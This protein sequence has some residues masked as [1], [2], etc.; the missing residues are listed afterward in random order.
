M[1]V[2]KT[3]SLT[4]TNDARASSDRSGAV[5]AISSAMS[6]WTSGASS[7]KVKTEQPGCDAQE[8]RIQFRST[9][10]TSGADVAVSVDGTNPANRP[11]V[12]TGGT[13]MRYMVH[14]TSGAWAMIHEM[15]HTFGLPDE[16]TQ[17]TGVPI[18]PPPPTPGAPVVIPPSATPSATYVAAPPQ[19]NSTVTLTAS[20]PSTRHPGKYIFDVESVMGRSGNTTFELHHYFWIAIEVK[21]LMEEE[22]TPAVV[23]II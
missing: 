22:G 11:S 14:G 15:G 8:L 5:S 2:T 9:I 21:R 12:V 20:R 6:A 16:Y 13:Q 4:Y 3:F 17:L 19:A 1:T 23:T 10:V 18:T 7:Y